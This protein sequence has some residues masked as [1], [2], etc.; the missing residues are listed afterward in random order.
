M[1][2]ILILWHI[3][4]TAPVPWIPDPAVSCWCH[5]EFNSHAQRTPDPKA[6]CKHWLHILQRYPASSTNLLT[7]PWHSRSHCHCLDTQ[8]AQHSEPSRGSQKL[9][10]QYF[11]EAKLLT[12]HT[13]WKPE[14][15]MYLCINQKPRGKAGTE[16]AYPI[17]D[18]SW[19]WGQLVSC[20]RRP[21]YHSP[22]DTS[23]LVAS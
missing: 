19:P 3:S 5:L 7:T 16:A 14:I 21:W 18:T 9:S 11:S 8:K 17:S 22:S 13:H 2:N 20:I 10:L 4:G 23:K 15:N 12:A 1:V 6:A